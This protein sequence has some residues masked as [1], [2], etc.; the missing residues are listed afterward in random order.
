MT[1]N[2][3]P[4]RSES[5][6]DAAFLEAVRSWHRSRSA[7]S[8]RRRPR[9]GTQ[10]PLRA[11]ST[12]PV[13]GEFPMSWILA[14]VIVAVGIG[15]F[16]AARLATRDNARETAVDRATTLQ[17]ELAEA[18]RANAALTTALEASQTAVIAERERAAR[19]RALSDEVD[20][21]LLED[22]EFLIRNEDAVQPSVSFLGHMHYM[23]GL[24]ETVR[25]DDEAFISEFADQLRTWIARLR[26]DL[27][28]G[29]RSNVDDE[30]GT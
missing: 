26:S 18:T 17:V 1:H 13:S 2:T 5:D 10:L 23:A 22:V 11:T 25:E 14:L 29:T 4:R 3:R 7:P 27:P 20:T 21:A 19:R 16:A 12:V 9:R 24:A 15:G 28:N 6:S 8:K 30:G